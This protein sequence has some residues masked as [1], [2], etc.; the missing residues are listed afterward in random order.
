MGSSVC[1][2][3]LCEMGRLPS[4][5]QKGGPGLHG[6]LPWSVSTSVPSSLEDPPITSCSRG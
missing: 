2:T 3:D 1:R 4:Q 5:E 6:L